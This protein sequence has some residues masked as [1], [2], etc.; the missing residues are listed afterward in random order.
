MK[1]DLAGEASYDMVVNS[2]VDIFSCF[3]RSWCPQALVVE[4]RM[5]A[6]GIEFKRT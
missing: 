2:H 3:Q 6:R 5:G 4:L 1:R